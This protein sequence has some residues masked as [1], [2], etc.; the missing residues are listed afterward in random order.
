MTECKAPPTLSDMTSGPNSAPGACLVLGLAGALLVSALPDA[1]LLPA[2]DRLPPRHVGLLVTGVLLAAGWWAAE[3]HAARRPLGL[4]RRALL[5]AGVA[6]ALGCCLASALVPPVREALA[7]ALRGG[8]R[9]PYYLLVAAAVALVAAP[10]ALPLGALLAPSLGGPRRL[11]TT[12]LLL[13]AAFGLGTA[14][15]LLDVLLGPQPCLQ[16]AGLLSGAGALL[17][18]ETAPRPV[19]RRTLPASA[20]FAL[21]L[22]GLALLV[23]VQLLDLELDRGALVAPWLATLLALAAAAGSLLPPLPTAATLLGAAAVMVPV[24][25]PAGDWI[26]PVPAR[27]PAHDLLRVLLV[28]GPCGLCLGALLAARRRPGERGLPL[29]LV[30]VL[31]LAPLPLASLWLLPALTPRLLLAL[32]AVPLLVAALRRPREQLVG[33]LT[34]L[35]AGALALS[36]AGPAPPPGALKAEHAAWLRDGSVALVRDPATGQQLLALDGR[37]P[38]GRSSAQMRR[39]AHLPLLLHGAADRVLVIASDRGETA[40]AASASDPTTLHWLQP[41]TRPADWDWPPFPHEPPVPASE[42]QF[43]AQEREPYDVILMAP[44]PRAG[45][46]GQLVGTEDFFRLADAA[47]QPDGLL[48]QWW[49][50][51]DVDV[52]DLKSVVAS[53][54]AVFPFVYVITDHPRT[55]R[56]CIGLLCSHRPLRVAPE[57]LDAAIAAHGMV[58]DDLAAVGLDGFAVAS[59]VC[60]DSGLLDL[61]A[62]REESLHDDRPVMAVRGALRR[63]D[64]AERL[65][66]GLDVFAAHRRD[67]MDWIEV[68]DPVR[69]ELEAIARDRYRSWQHLFGGALDVV[70]ERGPAGPAFDQEQPGD[71][72]P[73]EAEHFLH[74]LAGLPDWRWLREQVIAYGRRLEREGHPELAE[75]YLRRAVDEADSGSAPL[76]YALAGCVERKGD[77]PDAILLY[78]TVLAFDPRHKGAHD[79]LERLGA[80]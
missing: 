32:A 18:I 6:A 62:P 55:R 36:G 10:A 40:S 25:F 24:A 67:P 77:V 46:R 43:L 80:N 33:L 9:L 70:R 59:L 42:R 73:A 21:P 1:V 23:G 61:L 69:P 48:C 35:A 68:P 4:S 45:A 66:L 12:A 76:R 8:T 41:F 11:S 26:V 56:A 57:D 60:M 7:A 49:D 28:A 16:V 50:L 78:R 37:A 51:A 22:V 52:S 75:Q 27:V 14:P 29:P 54:R 13:G 47:L 39:M 5:L 30:P 53:A 65:A 79:A 31:L 64:M 15:W 38:F 19:T 3:R 2:V 72:P 74:A 58:G 44:D 20:G 63:A 34:L 71:C 17:L